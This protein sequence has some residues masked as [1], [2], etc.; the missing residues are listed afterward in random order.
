MTP[1]NQQQLET[2]LAAAIV[3][4]RAAVAI[5]NAEKRLATVVGRINDHYDAQIV[6]SGKFKKGDHLP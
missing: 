5:I 1:E 6:P 4:Q 3:N 2:A